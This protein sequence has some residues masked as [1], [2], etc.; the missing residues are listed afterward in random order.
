MANQS[1][2]AGLAAKGGI[3]AQTVGKY[4][5]FSAAALT[6]T[7]GIGEWLVPF[8]AEDVL[9]RDV[10]KYIKALEIYGM[11]RADLLALDAEMIRYPAP[12]EL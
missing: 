12:D 10:K 2:S 7:T 3:I 5:W 9:S 11:P 8:E 6:G 1:G 4:V